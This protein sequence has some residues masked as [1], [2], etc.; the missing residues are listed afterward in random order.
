[1]S[2][3]VGVALVTDKH[4]LVHLTPEDSLENASS[5]FVNRTVY[6]LL[7]VHC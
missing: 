5:L 6:T 7:A 2:P 3:E 1:M 4:A